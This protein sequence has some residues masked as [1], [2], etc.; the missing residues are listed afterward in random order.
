M[1]TGKL[2]KRLN[3]HT[4]NVVYRDFLRGLDYFDFVWHFL[5]EIFILEC[6]NVEKR[7]RDRKRDRQ[8]QRQRQT[9]TKT[10]TEIKV[11]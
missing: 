7:M 11:K 3:T 2:D 1:K 6:E 4:Q 9:E 5:R 8:R 10:E